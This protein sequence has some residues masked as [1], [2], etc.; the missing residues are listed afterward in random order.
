MGDAPLER[1]TVLFS[2]TMPPAIME[3]TRQLQNEPA[4]VAVDEGKRT[5]S[6]IEQCWYQAPQARKADALNLLLQYFAPKR[7]I[8]FCNTKKMVD[9]LVSY[10]NQNAFKSLG[11]HGDMRQSQRTGV[12]N[13]FKSGRANILVATRC[14]QGD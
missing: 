2:A 5:L 7:S 12:M 13:E 1:Q 4:L 11:L 10:L 8:V 9:E 3:I 14:R 6:T